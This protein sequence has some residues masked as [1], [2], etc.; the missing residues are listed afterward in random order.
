MV[1]SF[2]PSAPHNLLCRMAPSAIIAAGCLGRAHG[3]G[4][5]KMARKKALAKTRSDGAK[6]RT[7]ILDVAERLFAVDGFAAVSVRQ[8]TAAA[9]IDLAQVN[10]Y[11]GSKDQLFHEVLIRRVD[12][13]SRER[14][15]SLDMIEI[16][17]H[18]RATIEALLEAFL[19]P[20][21]GRTPDQVE[22]LRPYRKLI[23][24]VTN[25]RT[26][27]EKVFKEHYDP[28]AARFIA[29]LIKALPG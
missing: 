11:F 5:N 10:Y 24:L 1:P 26:W 29:A 9:E 12:D 14:L 2:N 21:I 3:Q 23:A 28:V 20:I 6:T 4:L 16:R 22:V 15:S 7:R 19:M 17:K 25:S 18:D 27:Q 13:M 8:I